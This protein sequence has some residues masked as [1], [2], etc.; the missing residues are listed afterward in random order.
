MRLKM[1]A[2]KQV[3]GAPMA[4]RFKTIERYTTINGVKVH[5]TSSFSGEKSLENALLNII[6]RKATGD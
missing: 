1:K 4:K 6:N 5:I 3:P 2:V